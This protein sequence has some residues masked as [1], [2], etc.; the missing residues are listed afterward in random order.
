MAGRSGSSR[1]PTRGGSGSPSSSR[2]SRSFPISASRRTSSS[3]ASLAA[4]C[5]ARSIAARMHAEARRLLEMLGVDLDTRTLVHTLGVAQQQVVE[6]AKALSQNARILVMDEPTAALSG[7]EIDRLFER[8]RTLQARR[9]GDRLHLASPSG[10]LRHRRRGHGVARRAAR[11]LARAVGD[12][13]GRAGAAD[14][15]AAGRRRR[16]A[17]GSASSRARSCSTFRTCPR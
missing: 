15:R 17:G 13:R 4:A 16:I 12:E 5:P 8:I 3:A 11:R 7:P 1:R 10:N 2:N 6:I 9:R 14:G